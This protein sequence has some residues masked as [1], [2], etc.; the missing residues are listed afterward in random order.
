MLRETE[1]QFTDFIVPQFVV[2]G[3]K[4]REE[5]PSMPGICRFSLDQL[6]LEMDDPIYQTIGGII[7]FGVPE[8][9]DNSGET[10][11]SEN[12]LIQQACRTIK[13]H[14]PNIPL[15]TDVCICAYTHHGHCGLIDHAGN[16]DNDRT[17][18]VLAKVAISHAEAGADIIA[19]SDMMDGRIGFIRHELDS[20]GFNDRLILAYSAKF[21][22]AFYGPFRE[23]AGS[24]PG[25]G[26]R[27]SYQ[28]P[29]S[30]RREA[31]RE[32]Q[33]DVN[34]NADMLMI[35]PAL[36]YL[37]IIREARERFLH[38]IMAYNVSG[39]YSMVKA[40]ARAGWIDE[41]SAVEEIL[42][43]IKRAGADRIITYH[44]K[45]IFRWERGGRGG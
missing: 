3:T 21:A 7:L 42:L 43:S 19:P 24:K 37:D 4:R 32:L 44:A 34:E 12:G 40:A 39:E 29:S 35:K 9:K 31:L 36:S 38:P 22:S 27:R 28:M 18:K 17:L 8:A 33:E 23:A 2:P 41:R 14:Y 10:A 20:H 15:I 45:D 25:F 13:R 30:N 11:C 5:I 1:W 16:V 26:D 6:L